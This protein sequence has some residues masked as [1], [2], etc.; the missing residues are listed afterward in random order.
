MF[1]IFDCRLLWK[2][3][4]LQYHRKKRKRRIPIEM[5]DCKRINKVIEVKIIMKYY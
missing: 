5:D 3:S 2:D 4:S 1:R